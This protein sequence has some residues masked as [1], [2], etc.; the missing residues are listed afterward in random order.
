MGIM[1]H[2]LKIYRLSHLLHRKSFKHLAIILRNLNFFLF[3]T[4]LPPSC[5]IGVGT[6]FGYK[7]MGTVI[8]TSSVIG[9]NCAIAHGV[10]LGTSVPY[11]SNHELR[12][13]RVGSNTFIGAGAM[14]LGDIEVGSNCTIA[15]GAVVLKSLPDNSIA[16]GVPA[17]IV[18][19]NGI[20]YQAIVMVDD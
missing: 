17:R 9:E 13:P 11:S 5:Q 19:S 16:V 14:I 7:G 18:G 20:E 12:G 2:P 6:L 8:H 3:K 10:T 1:I 4:Y 15:A